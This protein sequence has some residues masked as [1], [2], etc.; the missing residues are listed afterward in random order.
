MTWSIR[1]IEQTPARI[2][3]DPTRLRQILVN[4]LSNAVKF[5][6]TGEVVLSVTSRRLESTPGASGGGGPLE[7]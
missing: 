7:R 4:L 5:T 2:V 1:S 3:G 6:E